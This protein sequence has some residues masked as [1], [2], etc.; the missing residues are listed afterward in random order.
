MK[1][2]TNNVILSVLFFSIIL[3][4]TCFSSDTA[5]RIKIEDDHILEIMI[6]PAEINKSICNIAQKLNKEYEGKE[7]VLLM[8]M[9]GA[10]PFV[11][12][13]IHELEDPLVVEY[14]F[15]KSYAKTDRGGLTIGSLEYIDL[16]NKH[17]LLVDD[18]FDSGNT[19]YS[20]NQAILEKKPAS[21]K[22]CVL[23]NKSSSEKV[24]NYRPDYSLFEVPNKFV[25]GYG[26]DYNE[27]YRGL[28]GIYT[29]ME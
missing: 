29:L 5:F 17:V 20:I 9:K 15:A 19:L 11:A 16:E 22:S 14:I 4:S 10:M 28:K 3:A 18:I 23:L 6:S 7:I 13:L 2:K 27:H 1:L 12:D 26:L 21:V 25:V 24:T 8:V